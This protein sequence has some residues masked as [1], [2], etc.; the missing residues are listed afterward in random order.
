MKIIFLGTNGWYDTKEGNTPCILL[1]TKK[2]YVILDAG[3]GLAKVDKYIKKNKPIFL[4]I[5]H[6]HLEHI[7][8]LHT[9][10]KFNFKQGLTIL[11]GKNIKKFL[12]ILID[13]P[14][15]MP[16]RKLSFPTKIV[17]LKAGIY[18]QPFEFSCQ[19]LKHADLT[20]GFRF[21]LENKIISYCLDT[22]VCRNDYL[23]AR[24]CDLLIHECSFLPGQSGAWG[25]TNPEEAARLAVK[26]GVKRLVLSHFSAR[27]YSKKEKRRAGQLARSIFPQTKIASDGLSLKI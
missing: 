10:P 20:L 26:A 3:F 24:H 27:T 13:H 16:F 15:T 11:G 14:F 17:E 25:H 7:C 23:L 4:F 12:R 22:A 1:D 8:G 19:H 2:Y 18:H 21:Y 9:L 6:L 5:S